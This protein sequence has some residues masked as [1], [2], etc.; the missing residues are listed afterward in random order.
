MNSVSQSA[1]VTQQEKM[2]VRASEEPAAE[3][4]WSSFG[5]LVFVLARFPGRQAYIVFT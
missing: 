2:E 1:A 5:F 4:T 3:L